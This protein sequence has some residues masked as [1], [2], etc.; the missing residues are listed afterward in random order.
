[1][2]RLVSR[3]L[4]AV[5]VIVGVVGSAGV[6]FAQDDT[7]E[8]DCSHYLWREDAELG[9]DQRGVCADLPSISEA[10]TCAD[11]STQAEAQALFESDPYGYRMLTPYGNGSGEDSTTACP[12]LLVTDSNTGVGEAEE[13]T[14]PVLALPSTGSGSINTSTKTGM[15]ILAGLGMF[16]SFAFAWR[17]FKVEAR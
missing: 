13:G 17:R 5:L 3:L 16:A 15:P 12:E 2:Q 11:F 1:M 9:A 6:V 8:V 4:I 10:P 7:G 14:D